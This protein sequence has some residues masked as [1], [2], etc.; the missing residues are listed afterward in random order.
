MG[1]NVVSYAP[2]LVRAFAVLRRAQV[3]TEALAEKVFKERQS[4]GRFRS[5][6]QLLVR[7][8]GLG[9]GKVRLLPPSSFESLLSPRLFVGGVSRSCAALSCRH[10]ALASQ[11]ILRM[12]RLKARASYRCCAL[13]ALPRSWQ[14]NA[15]GSW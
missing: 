12:L 9:E 13:L 15:T 14:C 1:R 8:K 3:L 11:G 10:S 7:V 6:A 5:W 4:K 2:L